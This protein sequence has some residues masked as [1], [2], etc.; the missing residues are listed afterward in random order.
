MLQLKYFKTQLDYEQWI[1]G[2]FDEL[3]VEQSRIFDIIGSIEDLEETFGVTFLPDGI[4]QFSYDPTMDYP[5]LTSRFFWKPYTELP[6]FPAM[7]AYVV[8]EGNYVDLRMFHLQSME[9]LILN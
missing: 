1:S 9:Y 5:E 7:L 6:A 2:I 4:D 8:E 3:G